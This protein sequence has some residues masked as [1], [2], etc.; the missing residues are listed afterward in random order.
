MKREI[1]CHACANVWR[2]VAREP[3]PE[4]VANGEKVTV[5][6]GL[7][8]HRYRCDGCNALIAQGGSC[9]AVGVSDRERPAPPNWESE[10]V[11]VSA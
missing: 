4:S 9:Y 1:N 6:A 10:F 11:E 3:S 8:R 7:A 5:V 2:D